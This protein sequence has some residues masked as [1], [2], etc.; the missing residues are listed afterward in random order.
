MYCR[1]LYSE[2]L[3]S[4]IALAA[5][6]PSAFAQQ[7]PDVVG[8]DSSGNTAAGLGALNFE[9]SGG[10]NSAFGYAA[11][12]RSTTGESNTAAGYSALA[13]N[14]TGSYNTAVG[15]AALSANTTGIFN[16]AIGAAALSNNSGGNRN[17]AVGSYTLYS[18]TADNNTA[19]GYKALYCNTTGANNTAF[20][21]GALFSNT[22]GT[23]N[24]AQGV[25][26]LLNNT[27]GSRNLGVGSNALSN[28][29]SGS[30]NL[31]LGFNAGDS[32]TTGNDNIY[33]VNQGVADE[34]QTLRLGTQGTVGT[35]GS[36][37]LS[38]YI[39][40][41]ATS[42]VTGSA[43][44]ITPS[45]QLGVLASSERFKTDIETLGAATEKLAQLRP[46]TFKLKT[47]SQGTRQYGLIA[48]EVAQVYPELVIHGADGRIDGVRYEEL[49][50]MLLKLFQQEQAQLLTQARQTD[51]RAGL[52]H[53]LQARGAQVDAQAEALRKLA[54]QVAQLNEFKQSMLAAVG[55]ARSRERLARAP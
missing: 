43:L 34:S 33:I 15:S 46:V 14:T 42:Q 25:N 28:N 4:I 10:D 51:S 47:D 48:E 2:A 7:P 18:N 55:E 5:A 30:Y 11:L 24:E 40:G 17:T 13:G 49:T 37:I 20:G 52:I 31:A 39:A 16:I 22:T 41:V 26:A 50:P 36:G 8:S 3:L 19:S 35:V 38:A 1:K 44:Y 6:M 21:S 54:A 12:Y 32:Q 27:T 45:G 23:G 9:T 53:Q 29:L